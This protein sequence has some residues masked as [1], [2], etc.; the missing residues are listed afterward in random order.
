MYLAKGNELMAVADYQKVIEL[1]TVPENSSCAQYAFL[2]L[3]QKEEAIDFMDK[4]IAQ[5]VENAGNYYDAACL[6]SRMGEQ[7]KALDALETAF[8]K[9]FH[10]FYHI[11][12]DDDMDNI[13]NIPRFKELMQK[14]REKYKSKV[15]GVEDE[16]LYENRV[17]NI[18]FTKEGE[19]LKVNC[20]INNLPLHFIFDT[21]ASDVTISSVEANFMFK[22]NY[23]TSKDIVGKQIYRVANGNLS[24]G[25][26]INL[27]NVEFGGVE[28]TNIRASIVNGQRVPLLLGQSVLNKLGKIEI[29][30]EKNLL[31]ITYRQKM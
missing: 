31:K 6:Y 1:D 17:V 29:D 8:E 10:R 15:E 28:L 20:T 14:Q 30:N 26:V 9:G 22:N 24:E 3:G 2:Q 11:D 18:P 23:L 12:I 21:G 13:R 7:E 16:E 27:R 4:V 25:T 5:D 19:M